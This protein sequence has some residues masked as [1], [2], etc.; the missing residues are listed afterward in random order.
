LLLVDE[1]HWLLV[2]NVGWLLKVALGLILIL[3]VH[4]R[5]HHHVAHVMA[6]VLVW[7]VHSHIIL[8]AHVVLLL[9][10]RLNQSE[11]LRQILNYPIGKPLPANN[12]QSNDHS[13]A[14]RGKILPSKGDA[15]SKK[16]SSGDS[17]W[18][19]SMVFKA[20]QDTP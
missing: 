1:L 16:R 5:L 11:T 14:I 20:G 8:V 4:L 15:K 3:L 2:R 6:N 13:I 9:I 17:T 12:I 19:G 7:V 18:L 10:W